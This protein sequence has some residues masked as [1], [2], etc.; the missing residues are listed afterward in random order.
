V[1]KQRL[2]TRW[3]L[4]PGER[5]D[6]AHRDAGSTAGMPGDKQATVDELGTLSVELFALQDKLWA[7]ARRSVLV[8]LQGLDA[9][10][11]DG[12]IKH[13]FR[14]VNPQATRVASFKQPTPEEL[15]HDFLWRVHRQAPAAGEIGVFNRSHYEDVLVA[16]VHGLVPEAVWRDR[17]HRI[18]AFEASLVRAGT[19]IVKFFLHVSFEEQGRRLEE[20]LDRPDKI[21]K[22]SPSDFAERVRWDEY[23]TAYAEALEHTTTELAPWYVVPADHKWFRNWVISRVLIDTLEEMDPRYP[24][25]TP[26]E[27]DAVRQAAAAAASGK[28]AR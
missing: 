22:A 23:Q 18:N 2:S 11:K 4:R 28:R 13:V 24:T 27:L 10:G 12:S 8:V 25:R 20:R 9:S 14:G 3:R 6:L 17:Y 15:A 19:A 1:T 21:W 5:V 26:A 7:E 16:R